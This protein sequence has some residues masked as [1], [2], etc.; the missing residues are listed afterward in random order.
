MNRLRAVPSPSRQAASLVPSRAVP[1]TQNP[2]ISRQHGAVTLPA[3]TL[4]LQKVFGGE[5]KRQ[6]KKETLQLA[7]EMCSSKRSSAA[8]AREERS[9]PERE[10]SL[11]LLP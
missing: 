3:S 6:S 1:G 2:H 10:K 9:S 8:R 11:F 7:A 5:L 4:H